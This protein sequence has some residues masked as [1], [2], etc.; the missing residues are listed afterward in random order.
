MSGGGGG[1]VKETSA[2]RAQTDVGIASWNDFKTRWRPAQNAYFSRVLNSYGQNRANA[3]GTAAS[4]V[5]TAFGDTARTV[6]QGMQRRGIGLGGAAST[7]ATNKVDI[8]QAKARGLAAVSGK[9]AADDQH[10]NALEGMTAV[11]RGEKAA[12]TSGMST[13]SN[14]SARSA[15][16]DAAIAAGN[17]QAFGNAVGAIGGAAVGE[18]LNAPSSGKRPNAMRTWGTDGGD[19]PGGDSWS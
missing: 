4:D 12:A 13:L 17:S 16:N 6:T 8:A 15:A 14:L 9:Q 5:N 1:G 2:Q 18:M 19:L 10:Q 3:A 11:G 7:A